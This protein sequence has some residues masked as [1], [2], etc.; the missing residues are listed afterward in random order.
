MVRINHL[1][2]TL[3]LAALFLSACQPIQ[4]PVPNS[5]S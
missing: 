4:A 1:L 3:L 5:R 2:T